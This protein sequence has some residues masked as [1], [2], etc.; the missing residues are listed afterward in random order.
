ML[1]EIFGD[2]TEVEADIIVNP[3]NT[4][5]K[6]GGGVAR[7]IL[8]KAGE[9]LEKESRKIGFVPLGEFALTTAGKLKAKAVLHLPTIDYREGRKITYGELEKVWR[10]ALEHCQKQGFKSIATPLLG[11]GVVGLNRQK[12]KSILKKVASDF[13]ALEVIIVER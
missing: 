5:L 4:E 12:V 9:E 10:K 13:P 8:Q 6:H 7:A 1:R 2:I 3:A 11:T